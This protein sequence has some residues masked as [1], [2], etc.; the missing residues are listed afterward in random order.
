M[1]TRQL[2]LAVLAASALG[3]VTEARAASIN[4][5][6]GMTGSGALNGTYAYTWT[7]ASASSPLASGQTVDSASITFSNIKL[8][9]TSSGSLYFDLGRVFS[10]MDA[11]P[12]TGLPTPGNYG[13]YQDNDAS[14]D[15]FS[16]NVTAGNA[17]RL[18]SS[19]PVSLTKNVAQSW[20]YT[21]TSADLTALNT[22]AGLGSWG[23][24]IDPDCSFDVGG[25]TFNYTT[26]TNCTP[27]GGTTAMLLGAAMMG[28]GWAKRRI[29]V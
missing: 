14:G 26:K 11:K 2:V 7:V 21:F 9:S 1:K 6:S 20:T 24:L 19:Q 13:T 22:Y 3:L 25:I 4:A 29:G 27:D 18:G 16:G 8:T 10:G 28:L 12:S 5:P 15:A 23:F 17:D